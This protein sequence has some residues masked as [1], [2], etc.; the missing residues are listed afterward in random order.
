M[1]FIF[2]MAWRDS[3]ASRRL[4]LLSSLSV[5]FGIAALVALGSFS[6][7]LAGAVR[8]QTKA[9]L[10]ADLIV[11]SRQEFTPA[12]ERALESLALESAKETAFSSMMA[13]PSSGGAARL[14]QVR[15]LAG[16]F[17]FYGEFVTDPP[18]AAA[19]LRAPLA[20]NPVILESTLMSQFNVKPGDSVKLGKSTYTVVGALKKIAGESLA[21]A[22][23]APRAFVPMGSIAASGLGGQGSL[24]RHRIALKLPPQ[25]DPEAIVREM[26]RKFAGDSLSFETVAERQRELGRLLSHVDSFLSLVGFIAL[27]LGA[28]G[29][30]SAVHVYVRQK[31]ATVAILRCLGAS[32]RQSFGV[33]LLQGC[34]LGLFGAVL[35]GALGLLIQF[36]LPGLV[37]AMLPFPVEFSVAWPA[38]AR[39]M[40]SGFLICV[41]FTV[42]PLLSIRRISPLRALRAALVEP[43]GPD[44]WLAVIGAFILIAVAGFAIWQAHSLR[45]GLGFTG[46]L[47][48]SLG[49]LAGLARLTIWSARRVSSR[50]L[51]YV[52][53]QGIANLHRPNN[54]TLLLVLS[55]GLG[56]FLIL[57]LLL[58]RASLLRGIEGVGSGRQPNLLFFDIQD[59]QIRP[60]TELF[61]ARGITDISQ[62]VVVTMRIAA[63]NGRP[64]EDLLQDRA[65]HIPAW[66]LKRE[67]RSTFRASVNDTEKIVF[68]KFVA[69]VPPGTPLIPIS[70]EQGLAKDMQ[71]KLGDSIDWDVQGVPLR[72]RVASIR[73]VEWR[74]LQP[75]FFVVFPEGI[76]EDAPKFHMAA[77][78]AA[79]PAVSADLQRAAVEA[80]P[81]VTAIDLRLVLATVDAVVEKVQ[82]VIEF[83]ALFT[84][85][86]GLM[87]LSGAVFSGRHQRRRELVLLRVL[88]ASGAQ[89]GRIQLVEYAVL[90]VLAALVGGFL[91]VGAAALLA[92]AVF[93]SPP[94]VSPLFVCGAVA[95]VS[96][97]TLVTGWLADRG[98]AGQPPLEVLRAEGS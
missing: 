65:A 86:T 77:V 93:E 13:F 64:V 40:G 10:G 17:P 37:K 12:L 45:V 75:N 7:S 18:G 94:V 35:G 56:T 85:A 6:A 82:F 29:V 23:L 67:Y 96:A 46:A 9:L 74:R 14:V 71:L 27:L 54:R 19:L 34:A 83:M 41:L 88:G 57:T 51:P 84:V 58:A 78:R 59:D 38:V 48:L 25:T 16:N 4:L 92:H 90:G 5:V 26:K 62:A 98:L 68:G 66:T 72:T 36:I 70:V 95:C 8:T 44:P 63:L 47:G 39:G 28:I 24:V 11:T 30:A 89:L 31:I 55:L 79:T 91:A 61:K 2:K 43:A 52:V 53:R 15:A 3:R 32:A 81:N 33:Y 60:L 76:L 22:L 49:A 42:L 21:V 73:S 80:F 50:R 1:T 97:I 87:I 20:G 69:R